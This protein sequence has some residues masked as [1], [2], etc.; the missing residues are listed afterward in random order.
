MAF[1]CTRPDYTISPFT[2]LDRRGWIEAGRF[3]LDGVLAHVRDPDAPLL[4]PGDLDSGTRADGQV[5]LEALAR[6][7][8]LAAPLVAIDPEVT[9][10]G[11]GLADYYT[12]QLI[13]ALD[14]DSNRFVGHFEQETTRRNRPCCG[15]TVEGAAIA[16]GLQMAGDAIWPRIPTAQRDRIAE[17]FTR[18]GHGR[19]YGHNWRW[20][21]VL[22]LSFLHGQGWP[23]DRDVLSDHVDHLLCW[24][25][26][27]GWY[28]DGGQFDLYNCWTFQVYGPF[29]VRHWARDLL[30][31]AADIV[32]SRHAALMANLPLLFARDGAMPLWGRSGLYRCAAA[33]PFPAA[34]LLDQPGIDPGW[35]RRIASG[36]RLQFL[37]RDDVFDRGA[38]TMGFYRRF[39]P[40]VQSYSH[41]ASPYWLSKLF[42]ALHLPPDSPFWTATENEG[43]WPELVDRAESRFVAGPGLCL[44]HHGPTGTAELRPGKAGHDRPN[45]L[46]TRLAYNTHF[47]AEAD[48]PDGATAGAYA[49]RQLGTDLG[50]QANP[51]LQAAGWREGVF[52]RQSRI[53]AWKSRLDLADLVVPGGVLRVDRLRLGFAHQVRLGHFALPHVAGAPA[54]VT[55]VQVNGTKGLIARIADGRSLAI[56]ALAGWDRLDVET[57]QGLH[58]ECEASSL[59]VADRVRR[60]HNAGVCT[61]A[62]LLLHALKPIRPEQLDLVERLDLQPRAPSGAPAGAKVQL[63]DGRQI[64][65]D[66]GA[67]EGQLVR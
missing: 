5:N 41:P 49:T 14:P 39:E 48:N 61:V 16:I 28:R 9:A 18:V 36:T 1:T 55:A 66:Y 38:A 3:L 35:A 54:E 24:Y 46:Y 25:A 65:I 50:L 43:H 8:L 53:G 62:T 6:T 42:V 33:S 7:L 22:I 30:N 51:G 29:W 40:M 19:T 64:Q 13:A 52:Y 56:L 17:W 11:L 45:M 2:G 10:A 31:E 15:H 57:H 44:S 26:G 12:A 59:L 67:I 20:F 47:P 27:D 4:M 34:F 58:P 63:R 32:A 23:I 60:S 21:N 37:S